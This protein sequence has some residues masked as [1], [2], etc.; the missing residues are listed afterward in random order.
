MPIDA[1]KPTKIP[2]WADTG[3][4]VI[5]EPLSGLK[6]VGWVVG[7][8]PSAPHIDWLFNALYEWQQYFEDATDELDNE[9]Y[10]S[11]G[12]TIT[13]DVLVQKNQPKIT[14][15]NSGADSWAEIHFV[16]ADD[17]VTDFLIVGHNVSTNQAY[18]SAKLGM[19]TLF[20]TGGSTWLAHTG[21]GGAVLHTTLTPNAD[22]NTLGTLANAFDAF[23]ENVTITDAI[24]PSAD[25]K[26]LGNAASG[27]R[28]DAYLM[29]AEFFDAGSDTAAVKNRINARNVPKAWG[30]FSTDA[31]GGITLIKAFNVASVAISLG[32]VVV[33]LAQDMDDANYAVLTEQ[34]GGVPVNRTWAPQ[35]LK[36]A[37]QFVIEV[38]NVNTNTDLDFATVATVVSFE[39]HGVQT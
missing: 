39:V 14:L 28:F 11:T 12:G 19:S 5:T 34:Q 37:G 18:W 8:K 26:D 1:T 25:G 30:L 4:A 10:E 36:A 29:L 13:G 17:P 38:W 15:A 35:A 23:L 33:T 27:M 24:L 2:R 20:Q 6:D 3:G 32:D 22:A 21:A 31:A 16:D 7:D 9:K